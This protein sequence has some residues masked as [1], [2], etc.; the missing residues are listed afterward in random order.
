MLNKI[1]EV[2]DF[3]LLSQQ[4]ASMTRPLFNDKEG[5]DYNFGYKAPL[6]FFKRGKSTCFLINNESILK[7]L[8]T[9]LV[10]YIALTII[11]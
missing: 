8:V 2:F 11:H 1:I 7:L 9:T 10:V 3:K 6:G 4:R 5:D